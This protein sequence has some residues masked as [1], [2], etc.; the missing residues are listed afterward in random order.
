M[1]IISTPS[2]SPTI[3]G[4]WKDNPLIVMD[5]SRARVADLR[6]LRIWLLNNMPD[7]ALKATEQQ[8]LR[9]IGSEPVL[10]IEPVLMTCAWVERNGEAKEYIQKYYTLTRDVQRQWLDALIISWANFWNGSIDGLPFWKELTDTLQWAESS[11]SSIL[12]SCLATHAVMKYKHNVDR[13]LNLWAN[14]MEEKIW[15]VFDHTIRDSTHPL[16]SGMNSTVLVPHSRWNGIPEELF[17]ETWNNV[18]IA[19]SAWV[20]LATSSDFRYV[21]MQWHPE[22]DGISLAREYLRDKKEWVRHEPINYLTPEIR[23]LDI[24]SSYTNSQLQELGNP[25]N[26]WRDSAQVMMARWIWLVYKL[27]HFDIN[28]QYMDWIDPKDP[29]WSL[30]KQSTSTSHSA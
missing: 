19:G 4:L 29:L 22:Y 6:P 25:Q 17:L 15:W 14:W 13:T 11:V 7:A 9:L 12:T 3:T 28:K 27:T 2:S 10:Q 16:V 21:M 30:I 5:E 20:H 8:F 26:N 23:W 18:L 1:P 24:T